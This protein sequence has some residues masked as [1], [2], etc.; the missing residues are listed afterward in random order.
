MNNILDKKGRTQL[1]GLVDELIQHNNI[2][3]ILKLGD[4][5]LPERIGRNAG[6]DFFIPNDF[7]N[8][9]LK[10]GD[11]IKI[12]SKIKVKIP[13][14]YSLIAFNKSGIS[15]KY[16]LQ[17]GACVVDENYTGEIGLHVMNF[18]PKDVELIP[19]MKIV[20][21]ILL[22]MNY[23]IPIEYYDENDLYNDIDYMERGDGGFGSTGI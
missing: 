17:I 9:I 14:G 4:V 3:K 16:G 6:F 5:K 23:A 12:P 2:L 10:K 15:V 11:H 8:H 13:N 7:K 20:Q 21:F 19:G 1:I 18:G 22:K